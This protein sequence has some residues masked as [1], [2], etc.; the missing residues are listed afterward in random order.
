MK[1]ERKYVR[2]S[3]KNCWY[4]DQFIIIHCVCGYLRE[5]K[6]RMK[7]TTNTYTSYIYTHIYIYEISNNGKNIKWWSLKDVI[8]IQEQVIPYFCI[9]TSSWRA[10]ACKDIKRIDMKTEQIGIVMINLRRQ[11]WMHCNLWR[12]M[13]YWREEADANWMIDLDQVASSWIETW[14]AAAYKMSC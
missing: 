9:E 4:E 3:S 2:T 7:W 14:Q 8:K 6:G 12:L 11:C 1:R 5:W 10:A 13:N